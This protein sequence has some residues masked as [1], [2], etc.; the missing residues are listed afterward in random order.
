MRCGGVRS[1]AAHIPRQTLEWKIHAP[2]IDKRTFRKSESRS[3]VGNCQ[4]AG[5]LRKTNARFRKRSVVA[6]RLGATTDQEAGG[7]SRVGIA[8]PWHTVH[9]CAFFLIRWLGSKPGSSFLIV[10]VLERHQ[11]FFGRVLT[12]F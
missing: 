5:T 8:V 12:P 9:I 4:Q 11:H 1:G 10:T 3:P 7:S 2:Q 6:R